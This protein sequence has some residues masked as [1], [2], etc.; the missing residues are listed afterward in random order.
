MY[1][2]GSMGRGAFTTPIIIYFQEKKVSNLNTVATSSKNKAS[3][4]AGEKRG[5][6]GEEVVL[7][8]SLPSFFPALS[9]ALIFPLSERL[10]QAKQA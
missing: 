4:R 2:R 9:P 1:V 5:E 8:P 10:E 3:E 7:F 6:T